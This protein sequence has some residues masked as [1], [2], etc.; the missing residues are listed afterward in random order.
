MGSI[1]AR[2]IDVCSRFTSLCYG[3]GFI[4]SDSSCKDYY[5]LS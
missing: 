2:R 1:I 5:S 4:R 3:K